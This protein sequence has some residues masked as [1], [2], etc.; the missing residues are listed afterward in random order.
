MKLILT[1]ALGILLVQSS[2]GAQ[3]TVYTFRP[4]SPGGAMTELALED[5]KPRPGARAILPVNYWNNGEFRN[6]LDFETMRYTTLGE[7]FRRDVS[8]PKAKQYVSPDGSVFLPAA[9]VFQQGPPD[10]TGWRFS[11][12]LDTHG[13]LSAAPGERVYVSNESED[14]T[15][16]AT[17]KPDGSLGEFVPFAPRGGECVAVD[18]RGNVY[19]SANRNNAIYRIAPR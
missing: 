13:F 9:R 17:V 19:V 4:G 18:A 10:Y 14:I 6:Q 5:A 8:A 15:Y 2:A 11:D 16:R 1:C 12:N 7:M 3:G